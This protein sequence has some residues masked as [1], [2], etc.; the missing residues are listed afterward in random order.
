MK[1]LIFSIPEATNFELLTPE[2]QAAINSVIGAWCD[3]GRAVNGRRL[4][5]VI[6]N[7]NYTEAARQAYF[8]DWTVLYESDWNGQADQVTIDPDTN[9]ELSRIPALTVRVPLAASY[10]EHLPDNPDGT[11]PTVARELSTW[12]GWPVRF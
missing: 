12:A 6:V 11:R 8:P 5:D 3:I 7:D 4:I 1:T 2:Q 9:A 10:L